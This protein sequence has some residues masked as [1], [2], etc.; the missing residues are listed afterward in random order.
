MDDLIASALQNAD[1]LIKAGQRD[2][3]CEILIP[4]VCANP[5]LTEGW[6]LLGRAVSDPQEKIRSFQQVL[7]LDPGNQAAQKQLGRLASPK[8]RSLANLWGVA[9]LAGFSLCLAGLGLVWRLNY[10]LFANPAPTV[11][12][13][14]LT[15]PSNVTLIAPTSTP[16]HSLTPKPTS[17]PTFTLPPTSRPLP[18]LTMIP[19]LTLTF[20]ETPSP[21]PR[22]KS[23]VST[24][25]VSPNGLGNL[26]APFKIE[27]F[28]KEKST[29]YINGISQNGNNPIN[30][31]ATIK[32]GVPVFFE[33]AWGKYQYIVLR[34]GTVR[35]GSFFINQPTKA[36]MRIFKDKIQFGEFP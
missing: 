21:I 6:F 15:S 8:K 13:S 19:T 34:G 1:A 24:A 11:P 12:D 26:T 22:A 32:Q 33:L 10:P 14:V 20:T 3:A 25:C 18:S 23:K 5:K 36:T 17:R 27:N 7:R 4:L 9:G 31:Q 28:G 16:K 2:R 30:C 35:R 29:I